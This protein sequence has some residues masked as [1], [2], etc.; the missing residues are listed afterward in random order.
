MSAFLGVA[1]IKHPF[2]SFH[3]LQLKCNYRSPTA[4]WCSLFSTLHWRNIN[5]LVPREERNFAAFYMA[6]GKTTYPSVDYT[7]FFF[8]LI[9]YLDE[10]PN[11]N[12]PLG[13][14]SCFGGLVYR[15]CSKLV[16]LRDYME[17]KF[18]CCM[19]VFGICSI[20]K[21][22]FALIWSGHIALEEIWRNWALW[23]CRITQK[24]E[25]TVKHLILWGFRS[26]VGHFLYCSDVKLNA[27]S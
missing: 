9:L 27:L 22:L 11:V 20:K 13:A 4:S 14:G 6:V 12:L 8:C 2:K 26:V 17:R 1:Y 3:S 15:L 16:S 5:F 25:V 10:Q 24:F 23:T 19:S 21:N 18:V 7:P